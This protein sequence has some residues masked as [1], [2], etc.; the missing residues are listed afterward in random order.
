M[1][2]SPLDHFPRLKI[3]VIG[4]GIAGLSAAWLLNK[5]H[6]ITVFEG[7]DRLGGH[8]NTTVFSENNIRTPVDTGFIVYND[9]NYRNLVALFS[10]LG[11][12]SKPSEMSFGISMREGQFEYSGSNLNGL[13]GQRI[14]AV[15]PQFWHMILDLLRFYRQAPDVLL[16]HEFTNLTIGE[17]LRNNRYRNAFIN[18]HL[19]PMGSAIWSTS[20]HEIE[21]YPAIAFIRFMN[22]HGLLSI[23]G[24]PEWR[25]VVGGSQ[26]Y[27]KILAQ[28][29]TDRVRFNGISSVRRLNDKV[30]VLDNEG[31]K[32]AFD[33][34]VIATH[35]DEA[36]QLLFD[37][38]ELEKELLGNW[39]YT[40]NRAILHT[41]PAFMPKRKR[42]WSSWNFI[43]KENP[44]YKQASC[45]TYWMN[46]LQGLRCQ[47]IFVT[48]NP[49]DEPAAGTIVQEF[50]Y[51][52][53]YFD[54][55]AL[56][57]QQ[58]LWELQGVRRTWYCGSYFGFGFH[59]DALQSGLAVAEHLGRVKRPWLIPE[60]SNR[61]WVMPKNRVAA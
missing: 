2:V 31:Q 30:L 34:V 37:P 21:D 24:R 6:D 60:E 57:A 32:E 12:A 49:Y 11:V 29:F 1:P 27:V 4:T 46:R 55:R 8:S 44:D 9:V 42:V 43:S 35:A 15:K 40:S 17:Y 5:S 23:K 53:P 13:F 25:T 47:P 41:D 28:S 10:H 39:Q 36:Y 51:T 33:H 7:Q 52:H 19:L 20:M 48:L 18:N 61:I 14:N 16:S 58:R 22:S 38:D 56:A 59:E 3:A 50:I 45:I 26:E 54:R